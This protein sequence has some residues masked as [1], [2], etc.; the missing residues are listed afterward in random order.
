MHCRICSQERHAIDFTN[1]SINREA[2]RGFGCLQLGGHGAVVRAKGPNEMTEIVESDRV[3]HVRHRHSRLQQMPRTLKSQ[4]NQVLVWRHSDQ[5]SEYA[6][7]QERTHRS[8]R[9][10]MPEGVLSR[11]ICI[12]QV[13]RCADPLRIPLELFRAIQVMALIDSIACRVQ[14]F[15]CQSVQRHLNVVR[16]K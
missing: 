13:T 15:A 7:E 6:R 4:A 10:E 9:R 16:R 11:G 14:E 5:L 12:H 8:L 1:Q 2:T 3:A